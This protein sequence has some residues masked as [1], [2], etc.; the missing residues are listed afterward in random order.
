MRKATVHDIVGLPLIQQRVLL[1]RDSL[2]LGYPY[3]E[4]PISS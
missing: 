1:P 2:F 3:L 4:V